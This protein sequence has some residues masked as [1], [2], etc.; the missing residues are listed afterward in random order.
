MKYNM[1]KTTIAFISGLSF[2]LSQSAL[3]EQL[4]SNTKHD[5]NIYGCRVKCTYKKGNWYTAGTAETVAISI[6]ESG[7]T[8][9]ELDQGMDKKQTLI[10]GGDGYIC[11]I[12][13]QKN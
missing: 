10:M 8:Q 2:C 13:N 7:V 5:C 12:E 6:Y 3:A 11:S 9:I 4:I 1:K